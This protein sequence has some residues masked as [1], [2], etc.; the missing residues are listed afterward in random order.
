MQNIPG[1][2]VTGHFGL[3]LQLPFEKRREEDVPG[4]LEGK[5]LRIIMRRSGEI[6]CKDWPL[7]QARGRLWCTL[8][9]TLR[10]GPIIAAMVRMG[11][12]SRID[13]GS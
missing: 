7:R 8:L 12:T 3:F 9:S 11:R 4:L 2:G 1:K 13:S 10:Y 5:L 6:I